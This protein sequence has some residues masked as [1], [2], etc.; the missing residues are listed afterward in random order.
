MKTVIQ[1]VFLVA[2]SA[3]ICNCGAEQTTYLYKGFDTNGA[4][5]I[6]GVLNLQVNETNKV[7][8]DWDF[9][10]ASSRVNHKIR[11]ATGS[12]KLV[13][14]VTGRKIS[15]DLNPGVSDNNVMLDGDMTTTNISG[16]WGHYGFAGL[17]VGGK[18]EAAKK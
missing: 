12:G 13:G 14:T 5:V 9:Q 10:V 15:L 8:G 3:C 11:Q 2:F 4:L 1:F 18:F 6:N 7:S 17:M 16:T